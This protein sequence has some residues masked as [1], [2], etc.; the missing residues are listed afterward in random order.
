MTKTNLQN[1]L[2]QF[3]GDSEAFIICGSTEPDGELGIHYQGNLRQLKTMFRFIRDELR[4]REKIGN[5][6]NRKY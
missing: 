5:H 6:P 2:L 4:E 3:Q 1:A